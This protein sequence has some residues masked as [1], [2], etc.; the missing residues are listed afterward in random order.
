MTALT[1]SRKYGVNPSVGLCF[2]CH[3]QNGEIILAGAFGGQE[4]PRQAVWDR[5]PCDECKALM[6]QGVMLLSVRDGESGS[7]PYRTGR[8][9]VVRDEAIQ[10]MITP[11][12]L[13]D[14]ILRER[15]SFVE[16][17]TW[18]ALGLPMEYVD[19]RV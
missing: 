6:K 13:R 14:Q 10:R 16:D 12:E 2:F 8:M 18:V 7:N 11:P 15:V 19:N 3:K 4:A 1:L 17:K 9:V 5:H